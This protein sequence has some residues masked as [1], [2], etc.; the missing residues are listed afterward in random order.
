MAQFEFWATVDHK[1]SVVDIPD[2]EL[3]GLNDEEKKLVIYGY[4]EKWCDLN[5][6]GDWIELK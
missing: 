1:N 4:F 3:F 5:L 2:N 6:S